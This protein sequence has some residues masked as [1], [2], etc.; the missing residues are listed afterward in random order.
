[1]LLSV[2]AWSFAKDYKVISPDGKILM[3]V[4]VATDIKWSASRR[5]RGNNLL[6]SNDPFKREDFGENE[7]VKKANPGKIIKSLSL[8]LLQKI[9]DC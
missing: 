7:K 6:K 2:S 3:T 8:L 5:K 4:S 9:R 1:M